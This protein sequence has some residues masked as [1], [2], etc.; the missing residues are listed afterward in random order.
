[1]YIVYSRALKTKN[2][3]KILGAKVLVLILVCSL[4]MHTNRTQLPSH[5]QDHDKRWLQLV[6]IWISLSSNVG[7]AQKLTTWNGSEAY[8]HCSPQQVSFITSQ[9]PVL[10]DTAGNNTDS[11]NHPAQACQ[12]G[13]VTTRYHTPAAG[14]KV[15]AACHHVPLL[16]ITS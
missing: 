16:T 4:G 2:K 8:F 14:A 13:T 9:H 10:A 1:M 11:S 15:Q 7:S 12:L 3:N 5:Y 6:R